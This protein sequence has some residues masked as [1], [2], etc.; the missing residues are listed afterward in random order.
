VVF[1]ARLSAFR[2]SRNSVNSA[3]RIEC[4]CKAFAYALMN[5]NGS[6]ES[7]LVVVLTVSLDSVPGHCPGMRSVSS[8]R[9]H[10][11]PLPR[12]L[13]PRPQRRSLPRPWFWLGAPSCGIATD[14]VKRGAYLTS[15]S[16]SCLVNSSARFKSTI[17]GSGA[18]DGICPTGIWSLL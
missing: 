11:G 10:G 16:G 8:L 4:A 12:S 9:A 17:A 13:L 5:C 18:V 6:S 14:L 2:P 3:G 7:L 1:V 15:A